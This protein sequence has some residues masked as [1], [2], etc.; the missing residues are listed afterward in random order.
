M[1]EKLAK[2]KVD[3]LSLK[4]WRVN[5]EIQGLNHKLLSCSEE[6]KIGDQLLYKGPHGATKYELMVKALENAKGYIP[7]LFVIASHFH[8]PF[9]KA[10][11]EIK[12]GEKDV[13]EFNGSIQIANYTQIKRECNLLL[14]NTNEGAI[15]LAKVTIDTIGKIENFQIEKIKL[16]A[17]V[18]AESDILEKLIES[19]K[20]SIPDAEV[21]AMFA[22]EY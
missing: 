16:E 4:L 6:V 7:A 21:F 22:C 13:K 17:Q 12:N 19:K 3:L 10:K 15:A 20:P 18:K 1:A 14:N 2:E 11:Q 9:Y 8:V 5:S